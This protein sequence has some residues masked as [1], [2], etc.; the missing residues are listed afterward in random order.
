MQHDIC[1]SLD[2][3]F[4]WRKWLRIEMSEINTIHHKRT[5]TSLAFKLL[6]LGRFITWKPTQFVPERRHLYQPALIKSSSVVKIQ[7]PYLATFPLRFSRP[8]SLKTQNPAPARYWNSRIPSC[9]QLPSR[10]S[11]QE[12][13]QIPHPAKPIVYPHRT[14]RQMSQEARNTSQRLK[15]LLQ[16]CEKRCEK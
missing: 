8:D 10:I 4:L 3:F 2:T 15:N 16:R 9:F 1:M 7:I 13:G 12:I 14:C 6:S 5:H 11:P